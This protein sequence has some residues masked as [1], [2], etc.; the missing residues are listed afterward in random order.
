MTSKKYILGNWKLNKNLSDITKFFAEFNKHQITNNKIVYG[1]APTFL[2]LGMASNLKKGQTIII[3]QDVCENDEG[4]YTGQI[5]CKQLKDFGIKHAI[6]GHSETRKFL[7]C[8]DTI[9]NKKV[10]AC[11]K[12]KIAPIVCIG[13]S[14]KQYNAKQTKQVLAKQLKIIF[15]GVDASK[16]IVAY[17]PLWAIGSGKTPTTKEISSLC[18]FIK[19]I[20]KKTPVLYGGSVNDTN[21]L[22]I[23]TL[24]N[25]DGL[26]IGGASL[27]PHKFHNILKGVNL[28]T[29][30]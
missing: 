10:K 16:C 5:S 26:L 18:G 21:A 4:S 17:E 24:K 27:C 20:V 13:E 22:T 25:V 30:K 7:G 9:V 3:S 6:V 19:S 28:W 11:L 8:T 29:R 14:L 23:V 15:A 1:F 12:N 2:G